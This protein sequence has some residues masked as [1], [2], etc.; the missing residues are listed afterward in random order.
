MTGRDQTQEPCT[1][2]QDVAATIAEVVAPR[3]GVGNLRDAE[4]LLHGAAGGLLVATL[5]LVAHAKT[6]GAVVAGQHNGV[7]ALY[8]VDVEVV[9]FFR[10]QDEALLLVPQQVGAADGDIGIGTHGSVAMIHHHV[11]AYLGLGSGAHQAH[12]KQ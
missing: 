12:R 8:L 2:G 3:R 11:L 10:H 1:V 6:E 5:L 9:V 7:A 4:R